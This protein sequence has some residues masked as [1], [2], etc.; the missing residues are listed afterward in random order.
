M[1]VEAQRTLITREQRVH[2][3][4]VFIDAR[5]QKAMKTKDLPFPTLRE[6]LMS[7]GKDIPVVEENYQLLDPDSVRGRIALGAL[8]W[9]M[10]KR[11]FVQGLTVCAEIGEAIAR[12]IP[13]PQTP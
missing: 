11:P 12:M 5:G 3:F 8:P 6:Q 9:L 4:D 13:F 10:H 2:Q 1:E 7:D